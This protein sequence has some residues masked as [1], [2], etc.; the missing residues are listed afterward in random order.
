MA[1]A[2]YNLVR[3][4]SV[5]SENFFK[6]FVHNNGCECEWRHRVTGNGP[7]GLDIGLPFT[8]LCDSLK[9]KKV[10]VAKSHPGS[11]YGGL[12]VTNVSLIVIR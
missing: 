4:L 12:S 6:N 3:Y 11:V 1:V 8:D 10:W 9:R 7:R 2:C 5:K